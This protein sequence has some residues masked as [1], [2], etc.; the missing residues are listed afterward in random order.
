MIEFVQYEV[1]LAGVEEKTLNA[2][3]VKVKEALDK[4][5]EQYPFGRAEIELEYSAGKEE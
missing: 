3:N 2:I 5:M 1:Q 4:L